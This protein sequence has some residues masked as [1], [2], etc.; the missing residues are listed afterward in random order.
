MCT[1]LIFFGYN[2]TCNCII[3]NIIPSVPSPPVRPASE[4]SGYLGIPIGQ[5]CVH[6]INSVHYLCVAPLGCPHQGCVACLAI[7]RVDVKDET[8]SV[9]EQ[10]FYGGKVPVL[11]CQN[12]TMNKTI[13]VI[14]RAKP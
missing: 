13:S 8:V 6:L 12:I 9:L 10:L 5:P 14:A 11:Q 2:F 1:E 3:T 4:I 7:P